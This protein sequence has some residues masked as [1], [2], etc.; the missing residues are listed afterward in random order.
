MDHIFSEKILFILATG[1]SIVTF[2]LEFRY[3][4]PLLSPRISSTYS[5]LSAVTRILWDRMITWTLLYE[6]VLIFACLYGLIKHNPTHEDIIW[7]TSSFVK[8]HCGFVSGHMIS[9][10]MIMYVHPEALYSAERVVHHVL[11]LTVT[12]PIGC[13][14][15]FAYF[16]FIQGLNSLS[17]PFLS[18]RWFLTTI[19]YDKG[20][21]FYVGNAVLFTAIFFLCRIAVIP[22]Y[23]YLFIPAYLKEEKTLL[24]IIFPIF[25]ILFNMLNIYWFIYLCT[26]LKKLLRKY[27]EN[28]EKIQ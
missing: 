10:V 5:R 20:S 18:M 2:L 1:V 15:P 21:R 26:G 7:G 23:L 28:E 16:M 11:V 13:G 6:I 22:V 8:V 17:D 24:M 4:S 27:Q 14:A 3:L 25:H 12:I 9:D 19:G